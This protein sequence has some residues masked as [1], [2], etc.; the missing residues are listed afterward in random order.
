MFLEAYFQAEHETFRKEEKCHEESSSF[1]EIA[2]L[3][4]SIILCASMCEQMC[5]LECNHGD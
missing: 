5:K 1:P 3:V 2:R 4:D